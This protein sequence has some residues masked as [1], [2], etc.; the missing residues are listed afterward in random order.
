MSKIS[1]SVKSNPWIRSWARLGFAVGGVVYLMI[2]FMAVLVAYENRGTI[3]GPEGA[4]QRLGSQP[5]GEILLGIVSVG[6][7]GYAGWCFIQAL[8]DT[9]HDGNDLKGI[10]VRIGE[11]C[12]GL[13]YVSLG[14]VG[15]HRLRGDDPGSN[16]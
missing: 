16:Q 15:F 13:A 12:S 6:L 8:F 11:F 1:T 9:D 4:I 7:L 2:G 10:A 14:L 5:Y 3:V